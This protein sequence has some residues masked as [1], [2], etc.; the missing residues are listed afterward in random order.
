MVGRPRFAIRSRLYQKYEG[1]EE[2]VS[3]NMGLIRFGGRVG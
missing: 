1:R 3:Q 2:F